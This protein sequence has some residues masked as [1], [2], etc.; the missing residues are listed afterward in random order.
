MTKTCKEYFSD[1]DCTI[2][3]DENQ[4]VCGLAYHSCTVKEGDM[5]FCIVG[6]KTDGHTFAQDAID[7]GAKVLIVERKVYLADLSNVT[8]VVVADTRKAM[9]CVSADFYDRPSES[10]D[11]VGITGTNGKTTTSYLVKHIMESVGRKSGVIGTVGVSLGTEKEKLTH[12]TPES[13][14]LQKLFAKM[15]D[16]D[17]EVVVME[18]SSHALDLERTWDSKFAVVVFTNLTQDHLDYHKTFEA[19]FEAKARLFSKDYPAKRV[20]CIDS[21][22]GKELFSRCTH[23]KDTIITTGFDSSAMIHPLEMD[24]HQAHTKLVL[25][26]Q[27]K[28]VSFTYPL[29]GNYNISNIMSAF[30]TALM[31]GVDADSIAFALTDVSPIPGRLE[32]VSLPDEKQGMALSVYVDYA[33]TPDALEKTIAALREITLLRVIVVFGCG[34]NRDKAKRSMMG[35]AALAADFAIVTSDNPRFED[36]Q[37]IIDEIIPPLMSC[38][39]KYLVEVDRKSAIEEAI[40]MANPGDAVLIAGKGHEDYQII[41]DKTIPFDDCSVAREIMKTRAAKNNN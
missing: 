37:A 2:L 26:V 1:I 8:E 40:R 24:C 35:A 28:V 34:G 7:K 14:D 11:L 31:L 17:C 6:L 18:A 20:I 30:A 23:Q 16:R 29:V 22:W 27:G 10:F 13:P 25:D 36:P 12:T 15:R 21:A 9:A 41:K 5:F 38:P 3:G 33:H 4:K 32:R 39:E 19:Y